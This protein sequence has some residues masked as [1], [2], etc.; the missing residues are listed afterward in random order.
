MRALLLGLTNGH[1]ARPPVTGPA[2]VFFCQLTRVSAAFALIS[3]AAMGTLG[4]QLKRREKLSGRLADALAWL[5]LGSATLKQFVD[6]GQPT[7]DLPF[8]R[9]SCAHAL[10][11]IETALSGVLANL[12]ARPAAWLLRAIVFPIGRWHRPPLDRIGTN[13]ASALL[14]DREARL[15]LT[16]G[17]YVPPPTEPGLGRLEAAL[18][19]VVAARDAL[20]KI[21]GAVKDGR[22]ER[23][24]KRTQ[25]DRALEASIINHEEHQQLVEADRLRSE[26]I[27]VDAFDPEEFALRQNV[28]AREALILTSEDHTSVATSL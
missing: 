1:L 21:K 11:R 14:E 8:V 28:G 26:V 10:H 22:L 5:Y 27:Q 4:G 17:M 13:V 20:A 6:D 19:C 3:D 18:D 2:R 23:S 12:P 9:W 25:R 24:P 16:A 15:H 7:R